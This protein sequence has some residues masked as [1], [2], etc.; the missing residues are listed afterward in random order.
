MITNISLL[1]ISTAIWGF[2]FVA[3]RWTFVSMD[4]FWSTSLRH[5][6]AALLSL[7]FLIYKKSFFNLKQ[8][9]HAF[10]CSIFLLGLLVFQTVGLKYTSVAKSGFITTLYSLFVPLLLMLLY[11]KKYK[12][13][14]WLLLML[15]LFGISLMC[16]LEFNSINSGDFLSLLCSLSAAFHIIY[17]SK[18]VHTIESPLEFNFLQNMFVAIESLIITYF[19]KSELK[20]YELMTWNSKALWGLIFLSVISSLI[21]YTIQIVAQKKIP[22][23]IAGLVFLMESPFAAFF[24]FLVLGEKLSLTNLFGALLVIISIVLVPILG[25]EVTATD[26]N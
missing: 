10:I 7:P 21:A 11:R 1:I 19:F 8:L 14:F 5:V 23:H 16:N 2:G 24:A 20:V 25:R 6:I 17:L 15:A 9:K 26:K 12:P 3:A 13:T 18:I 22:A 4:P